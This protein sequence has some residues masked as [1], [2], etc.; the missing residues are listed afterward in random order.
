[1]CTIG[2]LP[3]S[4]LLGLPAIGL[5]GGM[6]GGLL[7]IGGALV[8]IPALLLI[9]G[10]PYGPGTLHVYKLAALITTVVVSAPA[11][12]QHF[13]AKAVQTRILPG[14]LMLAVAGSIL[15]VGLAGFLTAERTILLRRMFG[16]FLLAVAAWEAV[17]A[18]WT[19]TA[20]GQPLASG[21]WA[22]GLWIGAP[23]GLLAGLLGV[24]GGVWAVPVQQLIFGIP[25]RAAIATSACMIVVTGSV[26]AVAMT[27]ALHH[28]PDVQPGAGW[29]IAAGLAP[30]ALAG[31]WLGASLVHRAP[32]KWLRGFLI[33]VLAI[34]GFRL[35]M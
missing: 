11:T 31:G 34:T 30:G 28:M 32:V 7:G 13:R 21:R 23:S 6:L 24:G 4:W 5:M 9:L 17:R 1:M 2:A 16:A 10:E 19:P 33:V 26:C 22:E 35:L 25:L 3:T 12:I 20:S 14:V 27:I 29:Q 18:R 8:M 15:G